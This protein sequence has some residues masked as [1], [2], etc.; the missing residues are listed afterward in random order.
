MR[1]AL[2]TA[3][4]WVLLL[5]GVVLFPLP[6]PGLLLMAVGMA[7]LAERYAWARRYV[8]A[9]RHRALL[10]AARGVVTIPKALWTLAVTVALTGSGALWLWKPPQPSWWVLP[11][12]TWLPGGFWAGVSQALS[13]LVT[14][15]LVGYAWQRFHHRPDLVAELESGPPK[16]RSAALR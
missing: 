10:S 6:G 4:G 16:E 12:W 14:L 9:L 7:L 15:V 8:D 13:G 2:L 11:D 3:S 5:V 1:S